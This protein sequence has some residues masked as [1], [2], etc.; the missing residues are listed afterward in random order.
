MTQAQVQVFVVR[1]R[2]DPAYRWR[3][4]S[5]NHREV[6]RATVLAPSP[7][8]ARD[9]VARVRA[10]AREDQLRPVLSSRP[11]EGGWR[12]SLLVD[13]HVAAVS[14]RSYSRRRECM[15]PLEQFLELL[16]EPDCDVRIVELA[17][18]TFRPGRVP[19]PPR[20]AGAPL[21]ERSVRKPAL[22]DE[23]DVFDEFDEVVIAGPAATSRPQVPGRHG[24]MAGGRR[25]IGT[26]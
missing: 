2:N 22:V 9:D 26:A 20:P 16:R 4:L 11:T 6:G 23:V 13:E 3:V 7:I 21:L 15:A 5:R 14:H 12:W 8:V 19:L 1:T 10:L 18:A 17:P 25:L 24:L